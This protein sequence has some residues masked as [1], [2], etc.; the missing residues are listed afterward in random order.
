MGPL[1]AESHVQPPGFLATCMNQEDF[2]ED[3][4]TDTKTARTEAQS[5]ASEGPASGSDCPRPGARD[6]SPG[7]PRVSGYRR[8]LMNGGSRYGIA[9][10]R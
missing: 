10:R 3:R 1:T 5:L 7:S 2:Q 4:R 6:E 9:R 8:R